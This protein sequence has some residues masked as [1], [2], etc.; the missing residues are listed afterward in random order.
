MN[1]TYLSNMQIKQLL[2]QHKLVGGADIDFS[3]VNDIEM[4][5]GSDKYNDFIDELVEKKVKKFIEIINDNKDNQKII[6]GLRDCLIFLMIDDY[7][8]T[9]NG[10]NKE[11]TAD[12]L[13]HIKQSVNKNLDTVK[14]FYVMF[15]ELKK[16]LVYND[17]IRDF[18]ISTGNAL[19]SD[20]NRELVSFL[21]TEIQ[22]LQEELQ[23]LRESGASP[24]KLKA[25]SDK[26]QAITDMIS[27]TSEKPA[28]GGS[29]NQEKHKYKKISIEKFADYYKKYLILLKKTNNMIQGG[30]YE[31]LV[32]FNRL[33]K[34]LGGSLVYNLDNN[35]LTRQ[36]KQQ[37][38]NLNYDNLNYIFS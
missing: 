30:S 10:D 12:D 15:D 34:K 36:Q 22:N 2:K 4:L 9:Y 14:K 23:S 6:Q 25:I 35:Y 29:G 21:S 24:E 7:L 16:S 33:L 3:K 27:G 18:L 19:Y 38:V 28:M 5:N 13:E 17:E 31:N 20:A 32:Q 37:F 11:I 1:T 26:L 8:N